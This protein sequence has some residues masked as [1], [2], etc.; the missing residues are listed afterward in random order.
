MEDPPPL[1]PN[2]PEPIDD[3][4]CAH[5][6]GLDAPGIELPTTAG[7]L[8]NFR[9]E[10]AAPT[11]VFFYPR[12]GEPGKP[13]PADWDMIPGA[14]G[15]HHHFCG[16]RN[17]HED[18]KKLGFKVFAASSQRT[19]YQKEFVERMHIPFEVISDDQ[20]QLTDAL[21]LPTFE[22]NSMRLICRLTLILNEK[23]IVRAFYPVFPPD[24]N[25]A[26]VLDWIRYQP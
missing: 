17:L 21:S 22:Y 25:A 9:Q 3:G 24:K 12:T 14:R 19:A 6:P 15:C 16:F 10:A 1:P 2:L 8:I 13:S 26:A 4:R 23:K 7:R 20:F 5:L 11:V 18:F